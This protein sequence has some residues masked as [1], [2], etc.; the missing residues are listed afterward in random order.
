MTLSSLGGWQDFGEEMWE[1][2][3]LQDSIVRTALVAS[4][5]AYYASQRSGEDVRL[6]QVA[7]RVH[8]M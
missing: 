2:A 6:L 1:L 8:D 5:A 4:T 7:A 3:A